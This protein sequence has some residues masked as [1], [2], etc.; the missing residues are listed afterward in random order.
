M[1]TPLLTA[2]AAAALSLAACAHGRSGD[3]RAAESRRG[4][5]E[6]GGE[7]ASSAG[8]TT[9]I[10]TQPNGWF[11]VYVRD[12]LGTLSNRE[13]A[14]TVRDPDGA[15]HSIVVSWDGIERAYRGVFWAMEPG[16]KT[17]DVS[18]P[19]AVPG[20]PVRSTVTRLAVPAVVTPPPARFGGT[21]QIVGLRAMEIVPAS[22]GTI[23]IFLMTLDGAALPLVDAP[24]VEVSVY[25]P[26][27]GRPPTPV[28]LARLYPASDHYIAQANNPA[29]LR[30][31][32]AVDVRVDMRG[33]GT[34]TTR[35]V[36]RAALLDALPPGISTAATGPAVV[37]FAPTPAANS[38]PA[39]FA[40]PAAPA[41]APLTHATPPVAPSASARV[42]SPA[43]APVAG[44]APGVAGGAFAPPAAAPSAP[45]PVAENNGPAGPPVEYAPAAPPVLEPMPSSAPVAPAPAWPIAAPAPTAPAYPPY[46]DPRMGGAP[47]AQP[48]QG[49]APAAYPPYGPAPGAPEMGPVMA[50]PVGSP[51][52]GAPMGP[53]P[54]PFQSNPAIRS[55]R[56][57]AAAPVVVPR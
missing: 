42:V 4:G 16:P 5:A 18:V 15:T 8:I 38:A 30:T 24:H 22:D 53:Q 29:L 56:P 21:V 44:V 45:A 28:A 52:A 37:A 51:G 49:P 35:A 9:E 39:A 31:A 2:F 25:T 41:P 47:V 54:V 34:S 27:S 40:P 55:Y 26:G 10:V 48:V 32:T 3:P 33:D 6:H 13:V 46:G 50:R 20:A 19:A 23:A 43:A 7:V 12:A 36:T 14:V 11:A 1:R 57:G 17:V